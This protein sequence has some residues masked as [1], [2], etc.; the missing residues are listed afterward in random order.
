MVSGGF[1]QVLGLRPAHGRL[2][3]PDDDRVPSGHPVVVL[4]H[5]LFERR[6]G[7]DPRVVGRTVTDQQ[8]PD[9]GRRRGAPRLQRRRGGLGDRR[10][11]PARDAAGG[12]AHLG[13]APRR[14]A[15]ALAHVHGAPQGRRLDRR[16]PSRG[17]R[18]LRAAAAGGLWRT[19]RGHRRASG[20]ASSRRR[21]TLLPGGRGTSG[22]RDQSGTPLVVLMGMVGLVLLIACANV[23]SLL[24]TRASSRQK[25]TAV[26]LALG[27]GRVR[28]VRLQLV[29]SLLLSLAGGPR[30]PAARLLGGG[31][32]DP[33]AAVPGRGADALGRARPARGLLHARALGG[34]RRGLRPRAGAAREPGR[35]R[36]RRSRARR[37]RSSA[38]AG[39]SAC[40]RAWWWRRWRSRCCC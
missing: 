37:R 31:G 19:S 4:G 40:A 1:F 21:S 29:E 7:G 39:T 20:R 18:R 12:A 30:R 26:R 3:T 16:S 5:G 28:L 10:L 33:R 9:D 35:S 17:Q 36:A 14:L 34:H 2:F 38:A 32:A 8:P 25:E 15:L 11:R 24:L 6:F 22:L 27:A 23:A 13:Q